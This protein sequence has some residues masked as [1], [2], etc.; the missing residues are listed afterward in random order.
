MTDQ[1]ITIELLNPTPV[2]FVGEPLPLRLVI[3]CPDQGRPTTLRTIRS[4]NTQIAELDADIFERDTPIG[5]GDVYRCTVVALFRTTGHIADPLFVVLAGVD[6]DARV[7]PVPTPPMR[8][9]P[10]LRGELRASAESICTYDT[11]TKVDVTLAHAGPTRFDNFR[12]AIGPVDSVRAGVSDQYRPTFAKGEQIKF[13]TVVSAERLSLELDA[14]VAGERIGPVSVPLAIP[15]VKDVDAAALFRF[16]E[17]KKLTRADVRVFTLDEDRTDVRPLAGLFPVYG[18]G[19]KYRV[20]IKPAH[21]HTQGV[22]LRGASGVVEVSDMPPD[23]GIWSFQMVVVSNAVF[24]TSATLHFDVVTPDGPQ[25]GELNLSIRPQNGKLWIVAVTAGA[26]V[27][28][29]GM[30]AVVPTVLNP[31]DLWTTL[32]TAMLKIETAW[33]LLQLVSIP[34]I[35]VGLWLADQLIRPFQDD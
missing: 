2:A 29:K 9:V 28:V 15:K 12:L 13:S 25:Q 17:P 8:V 27:T 32:Q 35:R 5:P 20:E 24:T 18:G 6:A 7:V 10:S 4:R 14:F 31:G 26:A 30:A 1:P 21:P 23:A 22:K 16:L 34:V 33:D 19:N 11:G 3:R